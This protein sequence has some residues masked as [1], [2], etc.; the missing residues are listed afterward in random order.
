VAFRKVLTRLV[1]HGTPPERNSKKAERRPKE[2]TFKIRWIYQAIGISKQA[3]SQ[4]LKADLV[5]NSEKEK[6][7]VWVIEYRKNYLKQVLVNC[8]NT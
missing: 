2:K 8:T 5:W 1:D 3:Y 4:R 7:I 6:V